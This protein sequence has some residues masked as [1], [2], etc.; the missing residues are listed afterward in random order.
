MATPIKDRRG[1]DEAQA[2][3][4]GEERMWLCVI[5]QALEDATVKLAVNAPNG[6]RVMRVEARV[7]LTKPSRDL[8]H[9]CSLANIEMQRV[10]EFANVRIE[11][12]DNGTTRRLKGQ[13]AGGSR[14]LSTEAQGPVVPRHERSVENRVSESK[15]AA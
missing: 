13:A 5:M 4:A 2:E 1:A 8:E 3:R 15:E 12:A 11:Q 7:W 10:I 6:K 14:Q 9:V